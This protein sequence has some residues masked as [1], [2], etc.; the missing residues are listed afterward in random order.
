MKLL[1]SG[2][3]YSL[4]I[5]RCFTVDLMHLFCL[6]VGELLCIPLWS[7]RGTLTCSRTDNILTWDWAT[8][9]GETWE[10]HGKFVAAVTKH[11]PSSFHW[12]SCNPAK[13]ISSGYKSQEYY[14]YLFGLGPAYF[15]TILP[16]KYWKNFCKLTCGVQIAMRRRITGTQVQEAHCVLV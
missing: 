13:K 2:L 15:R 8:L 5:S 3:K 4:P 1:I 6:N 10:D 11:F 12:P 16:D 7:W 14:L 9:T